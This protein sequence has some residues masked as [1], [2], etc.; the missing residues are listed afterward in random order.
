MKER[1]ANLVGPV[2]E[3]MPWLGTFHSISAK[4]LRRHAELLDLR[5]DFTILD[6]DDQIR[7]MKQVIQAEGIDE[8]RWP[9]RMLAGF[10]DSWKNRGLSPKDVPPEARPASS[11]TARAASSMLPTR[12]G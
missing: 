5:S 2:A 12:T 11:P 9:G 6:T 8:K 1:V 3:G 4:L 7:L 10:I